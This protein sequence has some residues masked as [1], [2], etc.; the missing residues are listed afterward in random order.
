M[1]G[2]SSGAVQ[3]HVSI[4]NHHKHQQT[5]QKAPMINH[6][7]IDMSSHIQHVYQSTPFNSPLRTFLDGVPNSFTTFLEGDNPSPMDIWLRVSVSLLDSIAAGFGSLGPIDEPSHAVPVKSVE[8]AVRN[9]LRRLPALNDSPCKLTPPLPTQW[10]IREPR[11][12]QS[13]QT[14]LWAIRS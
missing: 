5:L 11:L 1:T 4:C 9:L 13:T 7:L 2:K 8:I 14:T 12:T 6:E 10:N 3:H